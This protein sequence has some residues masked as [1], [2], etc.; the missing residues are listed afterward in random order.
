MPKWVQPEMGKVVQ[1]KWFITGSFL[2]QVSLRSRSMGRGW[3]DQNPNLVA[4]FGLKKTPSHSMFCFDWLASAR[5][6]RG[7][8]LTWR[9]RKQH[10]SQKG[11]ES[12]DRH[13]R[14]NNTH[15][16][17]KICHSCF[18]VVVAYFQKLAKVEQVTMCKGDTGKTTPKSEN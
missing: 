13:P 7:I 17:S 9:R 3:R 10:E 1:K 15:K 2:L 4:K 18:L 14:Q 16:T 8:F 12:N 6:N 5:S 11:R